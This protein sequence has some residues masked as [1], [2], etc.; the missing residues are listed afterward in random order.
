MPFFEQSNWRTE[1]FAPRSPSSSCGKSSI[2]R[3]GPTMI[4]PQLCQ[5]SQKKKL[6]LACVVQDVKEMRDR[7]LK[8][9]YME[10]Q[11]LRPATRAL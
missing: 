1:R 9:S 10:A 6:Y 5:K 2:R 7:S 3:L 4:K 8:Q 11:R